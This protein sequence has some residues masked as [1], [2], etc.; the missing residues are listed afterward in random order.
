[1]VITE[2][3]Q[4]TSLIP[5]KGKQEKEQDLC[6]ISLYYILYLFVDLLII[7]VYMIQDT[8]NFI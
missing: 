7:T 3:R 5:D 1:M 4:L 8:R 2:E 6:R